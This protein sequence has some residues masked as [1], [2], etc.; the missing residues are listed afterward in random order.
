MC[1]ASGEYVPGDPKLPLHN[2]DFEGS[3]VVGDKLRAGLSLGSSKHWKKV[4]KELTGED[5]LSAGAILEY[6]KPLQEFLKAQ[7]TESN[8][9]VTAA[10]EQSMRSD[11]I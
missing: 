5:E 8:A 1:I 4:L 3:K 7:N 11:H 6:F 9:T 10:Q 2:C